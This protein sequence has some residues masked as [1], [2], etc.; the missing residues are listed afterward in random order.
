MSQRYKRLQ[1]A[2]TRTSES[3]LRITKNTREGTN[4]A[5]TDKREKASMRT[6]KIG[7]RRILDFDGEETVLIRTHLE[8]R[9]SSKSDFAR[10]K[11]KA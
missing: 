8:S 2:S 9:T 7:R 5:S 4:A 10:M 11:A 3:S 1:K 6:Q